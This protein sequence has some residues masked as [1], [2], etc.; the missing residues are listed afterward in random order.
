ML[1]DPDGP[2]DILGTPDDAPIPAAGSHAND[3]GLNSALPPGTTTD[4]LGNP[5]LADD[6]AATDL[7]AA[8]VVDI[9]AFEFQPPAC[10]PDLT[11]TGSTNGTPDGVVNGSD[12]TFY[13]SLFA[14]GDGRADLT[15]TGSTGGT[16]DGVING[17]DFT[18][19][20]T[21]FAIGCP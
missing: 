11:T 20:L 16:P 6:P 10:P 5:R 18:Y 4:L 13:L 14:T 12:F 15:T 21:L 17:S 9:G 3:R 19:F 1:T 7:G 8:P 2:D